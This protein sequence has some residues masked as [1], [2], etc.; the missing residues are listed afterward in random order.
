MIYTLKLFAFT[1]MAILVSSI[2]AA[3]AQS[4]HAHTNSSR[5]NKVDGAEF[6]FSS[7]PAQARPSRR[8]GFS[9]MPPGRYAD[10]GRNSVNITAATAVASTPAVL[11]AGTV[12]QISKWVGTSSSG[13]SILGD[14]II[15]E[16]NGKIG[17]GLTAPTSKLTVAGM[18]ETTLGGLKFPDGTTQTTATLQGVQGPVGPAGPQGFQGSCAPRIG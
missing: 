6:L 14:S 4:P 17:V 3:H 11:G 9:L 18:I 1:L 7:L 15:T 8:A 5:T 16:S 2:T 13:N 12:G 10:A